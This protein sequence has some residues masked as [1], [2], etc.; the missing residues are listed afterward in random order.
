MDDQ[1]IEFLLDF[2]KEKEKSGD[3][4]QPTELKKKIHQFHS[5]I[6]VHTLEEADF[7]YFDANGENERADGILTDHYL[8]VF[9]SFEHG[10]EGV[11]SIE[12]KDSDLPVTLAIQK[13]KVTFP[14]K[15]DRSHVVL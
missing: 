9:L 14:D 1:F 7:V 2:C 12:N 11:L 6:E 13:V 15:S 3:F 5:R 4:I 8:P 10:D